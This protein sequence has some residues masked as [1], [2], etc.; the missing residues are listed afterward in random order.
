V[1]RTPGV[2][3]AIVLVA[4]LAVLCWQ[5]YAQGQLLAWNTWVNRVR[6]AGQPGSNKVFVRQ[7]L[8]KPDLVEKPSN[9]GGGFSPH[10]A[11]VDGASEV[12]VYHGLFLGGGGYWVAYV[13][14]GPSGR[15]LGVHIANS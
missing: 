5:S 15:V 13:F 11:K 14:I 9:I 12:Y 8:G 10:P 4:V 6:I 2:V 3:A 1:K 7:L